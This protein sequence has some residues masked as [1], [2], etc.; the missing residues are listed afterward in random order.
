MQNKKDKE[1][2]YVR[3]HLTVEGGPSIVTSSK[4]RSN[5]LIKKEIKGTDD[6]ASIKV[7]LLESR[8][9]EV[10]TSGVYE[11]RNVSEKQYNSNIKCL[12]VSSK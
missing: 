5:P 6:I 1:S 8:V 2:V 11:L 12:N 3:V 4:F 9:Q 10:P 7:I